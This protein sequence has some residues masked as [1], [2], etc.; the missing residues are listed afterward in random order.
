MVTIGEILAQALADKTLA[1]EQALALAD[2]AAADLHP[3]MAAAATLR[4]IGHGDLVSYSPKVFIPL[5]QLCRDVCHYCTFAHPPRPG[6]PIYLD[7]EQVLAIARAGADA[8][9]HEA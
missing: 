4:D 8:G 9:C 3:L 7:A 1:T 6:E 2:S 5:T